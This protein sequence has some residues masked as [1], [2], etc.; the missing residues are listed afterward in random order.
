MPAEPYT[1]TQAEHS[2]DPPAWS[3]AS[4][5]DASHQEEDREHAAAKPEESALATVFIEYDGKAYPGLV[6]D[7][8]LA[9]T[10]VH[11]CIQLVRR[12]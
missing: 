1:R 7:A 3:R 2:S 9:Q 10:H 12:C 11:P 6:E 5:E 4:R 8:D